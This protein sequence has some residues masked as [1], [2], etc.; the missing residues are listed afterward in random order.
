MASVS[1][2]GWRCRQSYAEIKS[3]RFSSRVTVCWRSEFLIW[4]LKSNVRHTHPRPAMPRARSRSRSWLP[5][6]PCTNSTPGTLL[7]GARKVPAMLS[8]STSISMVLVLVVIRVH[9][10]IFTDAAK[11]RIVTFVGLHGMGRQDLGITE[12][13]ACFSPDAGAAGIGGKGFGGRDFG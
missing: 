4:P 2:A 7:R 11:L 1:I 3:R 13:F 10:D 5:P 6:H 8:F 9:H 12:D